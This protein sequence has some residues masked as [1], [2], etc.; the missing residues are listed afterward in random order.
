MRVLTLL[1]F[2]APLAAG[3]CFTSS[4][5]EALE[6]RVDALTKLHGVSSREAAAARKK[7]AADLQTAV[8]ELRKNNAESAAQ[9]ERLQRTVVVLK[10]S[11]DTM[12]RQL[13]KITAQLAPKK[14]TKQ[15]V[16]T[17]AQMFEQGKQMILQGQHLAGRKLLRQLLVTAPSDPNAAE[18]QTLLGDSY[19]Q[20]L[21]FI[22]AGVEYAK[23][24]ASYPNA[25][26]QLARAY[27][28]LGMGY[29]QRKQCRD[30][31]SFL[32]TFVQRYRKHPKRGDARKT[33]KRMWRYRRNKAICTQP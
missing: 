6:K 5:G 18:A 14:R 1:I 25:K 8:T 33:L 27:Y 24:L 10:D 17:P 23:V 21:K 30:A 13:A 15:R 7:I 11:V 2:I 9:I 19:Y 31:R 3:G 12:T 16:L 32:K 22:H 29:Y 28:G 20:Q 4:R 26:E